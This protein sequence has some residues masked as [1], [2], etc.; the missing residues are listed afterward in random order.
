MPV[1]VGQLPEEL[2]PLMVRHQTGK[3]HIQEVT[4]DYASHGAEILTADA[5]GHRP[6]GGRLQVEVLPFVHDVAAAMA[7]SHMIVSRAGAITLAEICAA[8]RPSLLAPLTLAGGHQEHNA[9]QLAAAGATHV[10]PA[11]PSAETVA[12]QLSK[13]LADRHGL[14]AMA[15]S[16]RD[17]GRPRAAADIAERVIHWR[18]K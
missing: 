7:E 15:S 2:G 1:V 12:L 9:Q 13:L 10:L 6:D 11:S 5:G 17:L 14:A 8:G 18:A 3:R 16:A 4:E